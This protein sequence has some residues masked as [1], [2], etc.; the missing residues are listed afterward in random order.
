MLFQRTAV[1]K[2]A[3]RDDLRAYQRDRW[4]RVRAG[5]TCVIELCGPAAKGLATP[6]D[7]ER[8]RQERDEFI[9]QKV[10]EH[11]PKVVVMYGKGEKMHRKEI[12]GYELTLD[13]P[14]RANSTLFL[15]T[16]HPNPRDRRNSDWQPQGKQL[17][18]L[19]AL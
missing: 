7:R 19:G 3:G 16:S 18:D 10:C 8:F 17:R 9:R 1:N 5:E 14:C 13:Q 2:G 15:F 4:G 12:A 11:R 6:M